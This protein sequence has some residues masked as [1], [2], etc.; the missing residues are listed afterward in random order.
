[1]TC[2]R[3]HRDGL[4]LQGDDVGGDL[5]PVAVGLVP[6][7]EE[8]SRRGRA[9]VRGGREVQQGEGGDWV[10]ICRRGAE[11]HLLAVGTGAGLIH[12]LLTDTRRQRR[13]RRTEGSSKET[14]VEKE[15]SDKRRGTERDDNSDVAM[16]IFI[17]S[18][19]PYWRIE[20]ANRGEKITFISRTPRLEP[21]F[22]LPV[23]I[24]RQNRHFEAFKCNRQ[25]KKNKADGT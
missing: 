9:R 19:C 11:S 2:S 5:R 23:K 12:C 6:L 16:C 14:K 17:F 7:Q 3:F 21:F 22:H 15:K 1:M 10:R 8:A 13:V 25:K 18:A 24:S 20:D 4:L